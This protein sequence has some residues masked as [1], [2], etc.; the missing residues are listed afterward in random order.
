TRGPPTCPNLVPLC[1]RDLRPVD[2]LP[3]CDRLVAKPGY[4][5]LSEACRLGVPTVCLT[6]DG[7]AEA[8]FLLAGLRQWN[9]HGIVPAQDFY[10]KPWDFLREPPGTGDRPRHVARSLRR[11]SDR[12]GDR[13]FFGRR[14][15]ARTPA[16]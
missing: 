1:G 15:A 14:V 4:S 6:R 5:T 13:G 16:R 7:F 2:V 9:R 12:R 11:K 10:E 8:P 3:L